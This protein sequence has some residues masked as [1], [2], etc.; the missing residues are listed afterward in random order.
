MSLKD[1]ETASE[2]PSGTEPET[3]DGAYESCQCASVD[4]KSR[5]I[6]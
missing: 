2:K 5:K 4:L 1:R 6:L 3:R